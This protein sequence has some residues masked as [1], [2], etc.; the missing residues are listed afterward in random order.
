MLKVM[1]DNHLDAV[2]YPVADHESPIIPDDIL[3]N[4]DAT[5]GILTGANRYLAPAIGFPALAVPAGFTS[6]KLPVGIDLLGRPFS[7]EMLFQIGYAYEQG[8][9]HRKAPSTTPPLPTP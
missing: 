8:T 9:K 1:A 5:S 3:T 2:A 7:E 6:T 4:P